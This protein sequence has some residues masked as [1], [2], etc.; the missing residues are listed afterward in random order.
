MKH[1]RHPPGEV[2]LHP[3]NIASNFG[4]ETGDGMM[5]LIYKSPIARLLSSP[6]DGAGNLVWAADGTSGVT[7]QFPRSDRT[8]LTDLSTRSRLRRSG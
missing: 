4:K 7:W 2:L 1:A 6:E 8:S 5:K 3:G